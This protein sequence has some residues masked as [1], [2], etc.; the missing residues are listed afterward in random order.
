MA[1]L[2]EQIKTSGLKQN[3]IASKIGVSK[4]HL[5]RMLKSNEV[6]AKYMVEI[7]SLLKKVS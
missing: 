7:L 1:T 4:E 2:K 6:P 5:N 3:F